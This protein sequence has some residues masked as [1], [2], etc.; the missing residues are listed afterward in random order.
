[1]GKDKTNY[2]A[3]DFALDLSLMI[4]AGWLGFIVLSIIGVHR[5]N[6]WCRMI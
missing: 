6:M 4:I 5:K 2:D 1:M 3:F